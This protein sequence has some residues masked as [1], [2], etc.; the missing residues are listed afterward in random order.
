MGPG[1]SAPYAFV[2]FVCFR[3]EKKK[4]ERKGGSE[5]VGCV[6]CLS[7]VFTVV[8]STISGT[9]SSVFVGFDLGGTS[10]VS[11]CVGIEGLSDCMSLSTL[12]FSFSFLWK[13]RGGLFSSSQVL[14]LSGLFPLIFFNFC[15]VFLCCFFLSLFTFPFLRRK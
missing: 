10:V 1:I 4:K 8:M 3:G 11:G 15:V 13:K 14:C 5:I 7:C 9:L 6:V 2:W 12:F